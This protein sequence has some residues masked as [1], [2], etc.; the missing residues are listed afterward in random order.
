[1]RKLYS[2]VLMAAVLLLSTNAGAAVPVAL[3][4]GS[5][6][7]ESLQDA[8]DAAN[9]GDVIS[10]IDD[11]TTSAPLWLGTIHENDAKKSLTLDLAGHSITS[12]ADVLSTFIL[13]HGDLKVINSVPGQ[14]GIYNTRATDS[15]AVFMVHGTY[16]RG[17]NPRTAA[18]ADLF[19]FLAIE[20]GV[21]LHADV[22]TAASA[23]VINELVNINT[24]APGVEIRSEACTI[25]GVDYATDV[26]RASRHWT[27]GVANGVRVDVKGHLSANKYGIKANGNLRYPNPEEFTSFWKPYGWT[28][29]YRALY[30]SELG[31]VQEA[32]TAYVPYIHVYQSAVIEQDQDYGLG[33]AAYAAGYAR[34]LIE[35]KC[36]GATGM[37]VKSGNITLDDATI[38]S[39][40][41]GNAYIVENISN[42]IEGGGN[43]IVVESVMQYPGETVLNVEGDSKIETSATG[44][45][46][47]LEIVSSLETKVDMIVI[48]GGSFTGGEDGYA[49]VISEET[50]DNPE[51]DVIVYGT[52]V[53][54]GV[55]IG[56]EDDIVDILAENTHTTVVNNSDGTSTVVVSTGAVAPKGVSNWAEVHAGDD[57]N[58]TGLDEIIIDSDFTLGELQVIT[59]DAE[60]LQQF[61][62]KENS[63]FKVNKLIMNEYARIIVE[64][65]SKLI[66]TGEQGINAPSVNNIVLKA[67][68]T[69]YAVFLFNPAVTSNRHP[70]ATVA[71]TSNSTTWGQGENDCSKQRF[72]IPTFGQLK[73]ITTTNGGENVATALASFIFAINDWKDFGWINVTGKEENLDKMTNPFEYYQMQHNTLNPGTVVTMTGELYGNSSPMMAIRSNSWNGYANSFMA[74]INAEELLDL[75]PNTVEK[76]FQIYELP[77]EAGQRGTWEAVSKLDMEDIKPMQAFLLRNSKGAANVTIDYASAVYYPATGETNPNGAPARRNAMTDITKAK[78][79]V[80]GENCT[81][82]VVVAE[83]ALF[84]AEFDDGYEASKYMNDGINMYVT[85]DEKMAHFATDNLEK[86][87]IGFQTVKGGD[88]T[89][90]FSN[91]QGEELMLIDHETDERV[92]MVEGGVYKFTAAADAT[93]DYRF[94]IIKRANMPTAIENTE[95]VKSTK[96]IYTLTGMYLG[97]MN[98]WNSLPAGIYVVNGAK[99]VK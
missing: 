7:F 79:V 39:V 96:G 29:N 82:R 36:V 59:G 53:T 32:D 71:F 78:L 38:A 44:G 74:P 5:Q 57:V 90:E 19:S 92:A 6:T 61:T 55:N 99:R 21:E 12:N 10:L 91:V 18:E 52:T 14:G 34:W 69:D 70:N 67:S 54:G 94:E 41:N 1:M 97:G 20:E 16:K 64:A 40:Y 24:T 76:S 2:L 22:S 28:D 25:F 81:D 4:N 15:T 3:L 73:S 9:N 63:T 8:I 26:Y 43:G 27:K 68:E 35:G 46:A 72:G 87:F 84:S 58:W 17:I 83:D 47:L 45:A 75:I 95:A 50:I 42:G 31:G 80:K 33:A 66:V 23:I 48:N 98:V 93:D 65:G 60:N 30:F 89:I 51:A 37:Y 49:M 77:E 56:G 88:Y 11:V 86:T 85:A 62:I 13:S